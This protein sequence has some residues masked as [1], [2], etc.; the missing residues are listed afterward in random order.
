MKGRKT[1]W[2]ITFRCLCEVDRGCA[3]GRQS[4][5]EEE[6]ESNEDKKEDGVE[7]KNGEHG[8]AKDDNTAREEG[9]REERDGD[10]ETNQGKHEETE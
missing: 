4:S 8:Q 1:G 3:C 2:V 10:F 6:K 5:D 9:R 7:G